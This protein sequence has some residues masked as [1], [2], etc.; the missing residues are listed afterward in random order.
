MSRLK[1]EFFLIYVAFA[2]GIGFPLMK[3]ALDNNDTFTILWLR[4][5]LATLLF[6]PFLFKLKGEFKKETLVLGLI[7]GTLLFLTFA[8]FIF[9]LNYTSASNTGFLA[10]LGIIFVPFI[11]AVIKK[12]FP[13]IDSLISA[14]L[15]LVGVLI[16][17]GFNA[18]GMN[19][20][21]GLVILGATVSSLH[22]I[23]LGSI[24][25]KHNTIVL[26]FLQL[27]VVTLFSILVA[28]STGN[29]MP[30]EFSLGLL[31]VIGITAILSTTVAFW[32]QTKYQPYTTPDRAVLIFSLEPIF[33]AMCAFFIL[34]EK[35]TPSLWAGG[36]VIVLAM[37]Y[38]LFHN[39]FAVS[40]S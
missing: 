14:V 25:K 16:I 20:G 24:S 21:D 23:L 40:N 17:S 15:G 37:V 11:L 34:S 7:L 5:F 35:I 1:A 10:G 32:I 12:K 29:L 39:K 13:S 27:S 19:F 8:L 18:S 2:W 31:S 30:A 28:S 36:G 26:T 22:I 9:G 3:S 6:F 4:F 38:P 33:T